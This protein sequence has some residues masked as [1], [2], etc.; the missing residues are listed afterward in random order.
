VEGGRL[1]V[2][3]GRATAV[4]LPQEETLRRRNATNPEWPIMNVILHGVSRDQFMAR[5][6][7]N[8]I[9]VAYAPSVEVAEKAL[10]AKAAMKAELGIEVHIC[11]TK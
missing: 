5:H 7:S 11:G 2:D 9:N 8:H 3:M 10:A 1:H 4:D 6:C